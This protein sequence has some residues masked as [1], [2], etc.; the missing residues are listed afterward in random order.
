MRNHNIILNVLEGPAGSGKSTLIQKIDLWSP[1]P[2]ITQLPR[3][4]SYDGIEGI[5]LSQLKDAASVIS[6][7]YQEPNI[8]LVLDRWLISQ[9]VY[10]TMRQ[11]QTDLDPRVGL[12]LIENGISRIILEVEDRLTR[13]FQVGKPV[14][15]TVS[16][17]FIIL[18]PSVLRLKMNRAQV[19]ETGKLREYPFDPE[20]E[21]R[22]YQEAADLLKILGQSVLSY[23][24]NTI[25]ERST[26]AETIR[27][28]L[29]IRTVEQLR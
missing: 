13:S 5:R 11:G 29:L 8:P 22:L 16:P 7:A 24:F 25:E 12:A 4:R 18:I 23:Q 27:R 10:G 1:V 3:P 14:I 2:Q 19:N 17:T 26:L 15:V 21:I 20:Q 28:D 6:I 9:W